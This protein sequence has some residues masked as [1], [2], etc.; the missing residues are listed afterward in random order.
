MPGKRA[1]VVEKVG[2]KDIVIRMPKK[3]KP[4]G[5]PFKVGNR[6]GEATWFKKGMPPPPTS[7]RPKSKRANEACRAV[8]R[9]LFPGDPE[10]R[11]GAA[12]LADALLQR[13]GWGD[14]QAIQVIFERA[15][16]KPKQD[17]GLQ[18]E[19]Q[20]SLLIKAMNDQVKR[21]RPEGQIP[22]AAPEPNGS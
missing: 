1:A 12:Y 5:R 6:D 19:S 18:G 14:V 20:L 16:G 2:T 21:Q 13:G 10:G 3:G 17:V 9:A 15:E 11:T 8:L 7:G 22:Y 4:R